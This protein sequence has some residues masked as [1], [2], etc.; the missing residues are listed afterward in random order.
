MGQAAALVLLIRKQFADAQAI[1]MH[2]PA[3]AEEAA[4][5]AD[6]NETWAK[7]LDYFSISGPYAGLVKAT[8]PLVLQLMVNHDKLPAEAGSALG[9]ISPKMLEE[10]GKAEMELAEAALVTEITRKRQEAE[11]LKAELNGSRT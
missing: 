11:K 8:L 5:I 2:V 3:I 9:V 10:A 4:S 6:T 7:W 1:G